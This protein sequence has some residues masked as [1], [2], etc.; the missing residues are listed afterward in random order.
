MTDD[1]QPTGERTEQQGTEAEGQSEEQQ[2][3]D[4]AKEVREDAQER[5]KQMEEDPPKRLEDWPE[6]EA[7]YVTFGGP[8]GDHSYEEGPE[9]KL[10]PSE[11]RR[12]DDGSIEIS[13][14]KVDEPD[15][16]RTDPIPGGPTD[17][18]APGGPEK[19]ASQKRGSGEDEG[20][21]DSDES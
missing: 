6:D 15:D 20:E 4:Q 5:V 3:A 7:K 1:E 9:A 18:N 14:E 16:Y 12:F 19:S 11:L 13:G 17:P 2:K 8:E 21:K 10:G